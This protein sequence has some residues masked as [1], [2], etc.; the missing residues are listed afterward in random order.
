M[1]TRIAQKIADATGQSLERVLKDID[2]DYWMS[3]EEAKEY[4]ILGNVISTAA[5][6][7]V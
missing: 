5:E 6:V 1:R 7:K 3:T 2:R 4:G